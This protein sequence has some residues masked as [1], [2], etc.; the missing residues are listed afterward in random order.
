MLS[1]AIDIIKL[2]SF[3]IFFASGSDCNAGRHAGAGGVCEHLRAPRGHQLW[4]HRRY[5]K[6]LIEITIIKLFNYYYII[7]LFNYL[8]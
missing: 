6:Y 4:A 5:D 2:H 3:L 8:I 7:K 1:H